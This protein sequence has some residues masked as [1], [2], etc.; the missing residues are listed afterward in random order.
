MRYEPACFLSGKPLLPVLIV[1]A[2]Y[3][4]ETCDEKPEKAEIGLL[5]EC[6]AQAVRCVS[7]RADMIADMYGVPNPRL[8]INFSY[9]YSGGRHDGKTE[10]EAAINELVELRR[11]SAPTALGL[12][13]VI[14]TY[15][16]QGYATTGGYTA[17]SR[18][19][20][21]AFAAESWTDQTHNGTYVDILATPTGSGTI[22]FVARFF[23]STGVAF[24][25]TTDPENHIC[26]HR[27]LVL[28]IGQSKCFFINDFSFIRY[29]SGTTGASLIIN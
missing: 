21:R 4:K 12:N 24:G 3:C 27:Y 28:D 11:V 5:E 14:G 22:G 20:L 17:A 23:G 7:T 2:P 6:R 1:Y 19:G 9:G 26:V 29:Q 15:G 8:V 10:L 16:F 18:A 25:N 13:D